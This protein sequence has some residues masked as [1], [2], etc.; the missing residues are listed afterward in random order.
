M[1]FLPLIAGILLSNLPAIALFTG[2]VAAYAWFTQSNFIPPLIFVFL[3]GLG[4]VAV[5]LPLLGKEFDRQRAIFGVVVFGLLASLGTY[6]WTPVIGSVAPAGVTFS[7][8]PVPQ[9]ENPFAYFDNAGSA[10]FQLV[11]P[12]LYL[13]AVAGVAAFFTVAALSKREKHDV[14]K[15]FGMG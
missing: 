4:A 10:L 6:F 7:A 15:I 14:L 11:K 3:L 5:V 13:G 2:G 9:S 1:L 8:A 12:F